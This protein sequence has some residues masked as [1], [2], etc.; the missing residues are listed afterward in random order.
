MAERVRVPNLAFSAKRRNTGK[1]SQAA[2]NCTCIGRC[3][4]CCIY[5]QGAAMLNGLASSSKLAACARRLRETLALGIFP[6]LHAP[7]T[8][9]GREK[10]AWFQQ[11][12]LSAIPGAITC[13][14]ERSVK[15]NKD[16]PSFALSADMPTASVGGEP[17]RLRMHALVLAVSMQPDHPVALARGLQRAG[18]PAHSIANARGLALSRLVLQ[19][20]WPVMQPHPL[21]RHIDSRQ[22]R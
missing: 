12:R 19:M 4:V 15:R 22:R 14:R 9:G 1:W 18:A 6:R 5:A 8:T 20:R 21:A 10:E 16:S 17:D 7:P 13:G 2:L 11:R 3:I